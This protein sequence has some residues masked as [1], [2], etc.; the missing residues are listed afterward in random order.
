MSEQLIFHLNNVS[1]IENIR[2]D[3]L[4]SAREER[5]ELDFYIP[6]LRVAIEVQGDQHYKFVKFFHQSREGFNAQRRRDKEKKSICSMRGVTLLEIACS[7]DIEIA[8]SKI[9][10]VISSTETNTKFIDRMKE[11]NANIQPIR[12]EKAITK[13]YK[14]VFLRRVGELEQVNTEL[15]ECH[16]ELRNSAPKQAARIQRRMGNLKLQR[17]KLNKTLDNIIKHSTK[18]K[19]KIS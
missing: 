12:Q 1:I 19:K 7:L 9:T 8:I 16:Q 4:I 13:R 5:L 11:Q 3:W 14:D 18:K 15:S 10:S 6:E 2:P 17:N